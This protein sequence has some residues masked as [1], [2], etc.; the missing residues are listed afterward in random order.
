[1]TKEKV[2]IERLKSLWITHL[3]FEE[4]TNDDDFFDLGGN[5]LLSVKILTE[6]KADYPELSI[7]DLL[8]HRT[9][10]ALSMFLFDSKNTLDDSSSEIENSDRINP[11]K[12]IAII[13]MT[14]RFPKSH[15]VMEL[16]NNIIEQKNLVDTFDKDETHPS[17]NSELKENSNYV[18]A[19]ALCPDY[20]KFDCTL[21]N[22]TPSEAKLMDPQH[23][24][25]LE[26]SHE[27]M[28]LSGLVNKNLK[29]GIFLGAANNTYANLV[30]QYPDE[31]NRLGEFNTML[32]L[33]KDYLA[34][35]VAYKLNLKG[36][37]LTVQTACSTSL[38]TI[39]EAVHSIR[40]GECDAA[41]AGGLAISG[42]PNK[43]H[44]YQPDG[45]QTIDGKCSPFD[46]D[47]SGTLFTDGGGIVVLKDLSKA[48]A[49]GD[50]IL[51]VIKGVGINNDGADKMSFMAPSAK[52]QSIAINRAIKDAN[53]D[54]N[55]LVYIEAHGTATPVG[56][57]IEVK[58]IQ[59]SYGKLINNNQKVYLGS[60]KSNTAHMNSAA[61]VVGL[62]KSVC[63]NL[64]KNIPS[65]ANFQDAN[66]N[67]GI[68]NS[69]FNINTEDIHIEKET[70]NIGISSFGVGGT[71]AHI[72]IENHISQ[73]DIKKAFNHEHLLFHFSA[74][75]KDSLNEYEQNLRAFL[76]S[77]PK[78]DWGAISSEISLNRYKYKYNR[79]LV[80][81]KDQI[82]V[83]N[84]VIGAKKIVF[85]YPG[86]GSQ[87][88]RMGKDLLNNTIF[89][90]EFNNCCDILNNYLK[91]DLRTI[92]FVENMSEHEAFDALKNTYY[93]QPALFAIEYSMTRMLESFG[94]KPDALI[95][96][97]IGEFVS[98][99]IGGVFSLED[100]LKLVSSRARFMETLDRGSM[101]SIGE[102]F[103]NYKGELDPDIQLAAINGPKMTVVAGPTTNIEQLIKKLN[104]KNIKNKLLHTSHA[105]HSKMMFPIYDSF[106][107]I[108]KS[109]SLS[110]PKIDMYSTVTTSIESD[111]FTDPEYWIEHMGAT[112]KFAPT[113]E[114][115]MADHPSAIFLE[116][117]PRATLTVLSR[118]VAINLGKKS[119][120][121]INTLK[122]ESINEQFSINKAVAYLWC[123]GKEESKKLFFIDQDK[124]YADAPT[125]PFLNQRHWLEW[126]TQSIPQTNNSIDSLIKNMEGT[127]MSKENQIKGKVV[128]IFEESSGLV[129]TDFDSD[130]T[131]I[132]MGM[133]SLF[134]T[135]ISLNLKK[136]FNT[137]ISF[138]ELVDT[139][140]TL[141]LLTNTLI[142]KVDSTYFKD[143]PISSSVSQGIPTNISLQP[144]SINPSA[145]IGSVQ[146]LINR[147]LEIM[148]NQLLLLSGNKQI[149]NSQS[150]E[151]IMQ[152]EVSSKVDH[153]ATKKIKKTDVDNSYSAFGAIAKITTKNKNIISSEQQSFI[154][155]LFSKYMKKTESSKTFTQKNRKTHAD[156]RV[157]SGFK[158][159]TK[160]VTYPIVVKKSKANHLWDIDGNEYIDIT[161]GFGSNFFGNGHP[162]ITKYVKEQIDNGLEIGPQHP[163]TED[164]SKLV[165]ELTGHERAG[166]CNT[167]SEAVL[168]CMRIARTISGKE[169][170]ISFNGSYH[171]INDEVIVRGVRGGRP[172]PAAPGINSESVKNM[173]VLDYGTEESF[174]Y[175][176]K[177]IHEIA[178]IMVEPVQ[179]R[180]SDYHP[181]EFLQKL[182]DI[183]SAND[184]CFI[185]DEV[186][187]G[188]RIATGGAQEYF[189]IKADLA[190]YGKVVGGGMPI[191]VVAGSAKY[192]DALDGGHWQYG[193]DSGP[194]VGVT[195]FAGT[196]VRHPLA[197]A[198]AKGALEIIKEGGNELLDRVNGR[199]DKFAAKLNLFCK[200]SNI[201]LT[202]DN[203][204]SIMKPRWLVDAP[205]SDLLFVSL[206]ESGIHVYDGFPWYINIAHT[207][208]DLVT[209]M[210]TV[211]DQLLLLQSK[212]LIP[213][214][215][216][217]GDSVPPVEGALLMQDDD[218]NVD[219]FMK[220][221]DGNYERV[222]R[223]N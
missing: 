216:S 192:M 75:T 150:I 50:N 181:K 66:P 223:E 120:S 113:I 70:F 14:G 187:T 18:F 25:A 88:L 21:F 178:A 159:L 128:K 47:S 133:D 183:T 90:D 73:N 41:L 62:I 80:L 15:S 148:S 27:A 131:F 102:N 13:A 221:S 24:K 108:V 6:L 215:K 53:I 8:E 64:N 144:T 33:E 164:V 99:V 71:N 74:K 97:S 151:S 94:I 26:L 1:M 28:E 60:V 38:V 84:G 68:A 208:E 110:K 138:R 155:D 219:W 57:P 191:G 105:F 16:W 55:N 176:K 42:L 179:S 123:H 170:I 7:V 86:Q 136:E 98:G 82:D 145:P 59:D 89:A 17:V 161:C 40:R 107:E 121:A 198:A 166:F 146:D 196:F 32:G 114:S 46:K 29:V 117:G 195:Y 65:M 109:V 207:E 177:H 139:I 203:F 174:E 92:I 184:V 125:Y 172:V 202:I 143:V 23:R 200:L 5:S 111:M 222:V 58:G 201:P 160:E 171:G 85:M 124:R 135:Q 48:I 43:G 39:I 101:L 100:G 154:N 76:S 93:T 35:R 190:A 12:D 81:H 115:V 3:Q 194:T 212:G 63:I 165:C 193:D 118:K 78:E 157:V 112:V 149:H 49:D 19:S 147:Q 45:I 209:I 141:D 122:D 34:A 22:I 218:G 182:R 129:L 185:F 137:E 175:I 87:Y 91:I 2:F 213:S 152:H 52:G 37:A 30:A 169:K 214:L 11:S 31:V 204:G 95:G 134:L 220:T 4:F 126:K 180:K 163:L 116:I 130:M 61:G 132:E 142:K 103:D 10:N 83:V 106:R 9:I 173:I 168:G 72:I 197:L 156:P 158:P 127:L 205:F 79:T 210:N 140:S 96:H 44:L 69:S 188:F 119:F 211:Q 67:L 104:N 54:I 186:I 189:G 162:H 199:A 56:D 36:P 51:S 20:D 77:K 206:K 217:T 153:K 167:G